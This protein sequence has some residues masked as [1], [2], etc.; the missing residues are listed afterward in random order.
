MYMPA[1]VDIKI[2]PVQIIPAVAQTGQLIPDTLLPKT[3]PLNLQPPGGK[4]LPDDHV[5]H[6]PGEQHSHERGDTGVDHVVSPKYPRL[7][8]HDQDDKYG[9]RYKIK[10]E[11]PQGVK[12][13]DNLTTDQKDEQERRTLLRPLDHINV[14]AKSYKT[15]IEEQK[16]DNYAKTAEPPGFAHMTREKKH[17]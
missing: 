12:H 6:I 2:H 7:E 4:D 11:D 14:Q 17:K 16:S 15:A 1:N 5:G 8:G 10:R 13:K 3:V 9:Y